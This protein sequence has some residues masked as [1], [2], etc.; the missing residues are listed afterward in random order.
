[1][2]VPGR[3]PNPNSLNRNAPSVDWTDG[4]DKPFR[5][6]PPVD[7]PPTKRVVDED[8]PNWIAAP[9]YDLDRT[10]RVCFGWYWFDDHSEA[11]AVLL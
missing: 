4:S 8:G 7:L 6:K 9:N 11:E 1:V 2:A 3:E 10:R 5:G